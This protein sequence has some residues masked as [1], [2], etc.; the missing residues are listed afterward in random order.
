[1]TEHTWCYISQ[2]TVVNKFNFVCEYEVTP[3]FQA[4]S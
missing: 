2:I 1:M 4:M 3:I